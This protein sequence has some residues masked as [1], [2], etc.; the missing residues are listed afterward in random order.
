VRRLTTSTNDDP[1]IDI[2]GEDFS[3]APQ[4]APVNGLGWGT[5]TADGGQVITS[6]LAPQ[7]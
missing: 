4:T 1:P 2:I 3:S 6:F 7:P 5:P